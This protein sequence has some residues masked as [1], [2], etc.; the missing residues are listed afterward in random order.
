MEAFRGAAPWFVFWYDHPSWKTGVWRCEVNADIDQPLYTAY[1]PS[2]LGFHNDMTRYVWPPEYT[3]IRC[4]RMDESG[5]ENLLLYVDDVISRLREDGR[6]D[7]LD[8]LSRPRSLSVEARHMAPGTS[9]SD[10]IESAILVEGDEAMPSRVF[11]RHA[12]SK[13]THLAMSEGDIA[14]YDEF[15]DLCNEF[16]DIMVQTL[17]E[18]GDLLLFSNWRFLHSRTQ[19]AGSRRV[20]EICMG[21]APVGAPAHYR[22]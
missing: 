11:D 2:L 20:T 22:N 19:C 16:H 7:I 21:W 10:L 15:L 6:R 17:L 8:M 3:A 18:P 13:G 9:P 5:G 4:I 14:L 1:R 12:A